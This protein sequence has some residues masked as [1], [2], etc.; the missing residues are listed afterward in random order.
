MVDETKPPKGWRWEA[1]G[2]DS[3]RVRRPVVYGC[4]LTEAHRIAREEAQPYIAEALERIAAWLAVELEF[5]ADEAAEQVRAMARGERP[6]PGSE[7]G[8]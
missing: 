7:G 3:E 4:P 2:P 6:L 5:C 1:H 8:T